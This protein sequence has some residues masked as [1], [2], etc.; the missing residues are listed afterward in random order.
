MNVW[1]DIKQTLYIGILML[2]WA[3]AG[4]SFKLAFEN[5]GY[6]YDFYFAML[7]CIYFAG[8][9]MYSFDAWRDEQDY[10]NLMYDIE[11]CA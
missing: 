4:Y 10:W 2:Y 9:F 8:A 6:M 5:L 7:P 11:V 1:D 3:L